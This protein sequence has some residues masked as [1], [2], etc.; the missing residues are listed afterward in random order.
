MGE[1]VAS[2]RVIRI[3]SEKLEMDKEEV[4]LEASF[5]DLGADCLDVVE[6]IM[7][8]E[9][10]FKLSITDQEAQ[11]IKTVGDAVKYIEDHRGE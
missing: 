10:T 7:D 1:Q 4:K 8:L 5:A 2:D 6:L 11:S 9:D 3:V